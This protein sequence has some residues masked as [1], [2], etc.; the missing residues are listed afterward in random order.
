MED[1]AV[2][3]RMGEETMKDLSEVGDS[4]MRYLEWLIE[5]KDFEAIEKLRPIV[6]KMNAVFMGIQEGAFP[7]IGRSL[8]AMNQFADE[9][10]RRLAQVQT[11]EEFEQLSREV[12]MIQKE[13]DDFKAEI[14]SGEGTIKKNQKH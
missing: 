13:L 5:R 10:K 3:F 9:I 12:E 1:K 11:P 6:D 4:L 8:D 7:E 2:V 14:N